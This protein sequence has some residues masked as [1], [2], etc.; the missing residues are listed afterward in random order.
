MLIR[1]QYR[2][3]TFGRV[4][5]EDL[6]ELIQNG[7]II[8]FERS[9]GWAHVRHTGLRRRKGRF[10]CVPERRASL[11]YRQFLDLLE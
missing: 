5:S 8:Q 11:A 9:D 10:Y 3:G 4:K 1:V 6:E 7:D 2:N